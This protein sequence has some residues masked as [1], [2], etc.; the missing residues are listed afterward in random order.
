MLHYRVVKTKGNSRSVQVYRY[1]K[2]K[3][4]IIKHIGSSTCEEEITSFKEMAKLY[5]V[6]C[7][8]QAY[9]FETE[10]PREDAVLVQQCEF[11]GIH[12]TYF[13]DVIRALQHDL[14]YTLHCDTLL[15]DLVIM[16][17]F[18]PS[19]KLRSIEL[20]EHYF[21]IKHRRQ[22]FYDSAKNW[23]VFKGKN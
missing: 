19:S 16:R 13:Y 15:N 2:G 5:I 9:L 18:E 21:G 12:Y 23:I 4:V 3:R 7:T 11:I 6:D 17:I 20:L 22:R 10:K 8:K 14:G 1:N